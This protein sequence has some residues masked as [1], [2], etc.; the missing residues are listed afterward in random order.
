MILNELENMLHEKKVDYVRKFQKAVDKVN[1]LINKA[2]ETEISAI[3]PDSTWE[4]SYEFEPV[5]LTP[6]HL[7]IKYNEWNGRKTEPKTEKI[8]FAQDRDEYPEFAETKHNLRWIAKAIKKGFREEGQS[9]EEDAAKDDIALD[10]RDLV[11]RLKTDD[12]EDDGGMN[13]QL[14]SDLVDN[15]WEKYGIGYYVH[16]EHP[17]IV[18]DMHAGEFGKTVPNEDLD[19]AGLHFQTYFQTYEKLVDKLNSDYYKSFLNRVAKFKNNV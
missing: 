1:V 11:S 16:D 15:G 10:D 19:D 18:L 17:Y 7:I 14:L 4:T 9:F 8:S 6:T 13:K 3:E 2:K 5:I 12:S